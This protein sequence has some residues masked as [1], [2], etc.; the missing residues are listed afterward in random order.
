MLTPEGMTRVLIAAT[1]SQMEPVIREIYRQN[2]F[3][4]EEFVEKDRKEYE[5]Y[6]IGTPLPQAN[7]TSRELLRLRGITNAFMIREDE[8]GNAGERQKTEHLA[9]LIEKELPS[10]EKGVEDLLAR[11][12]H[13]DTQ[14]K[15]YEQK[16]EGLKP[17]QD[18]PLDL[19]L[20]RGYRSFSVFCGYISRELSLDIPH[21]IY[22]T[23]SKKAKLITLVVSNNDRSAAEQAL[24]DAQFQAVPV[25]EEEGLAKTRIG[26]YESQLLSVKGELEEINRRLD[27]IKKEHKGL[28]LACNEL[29]TADIEMAEAP[30]RFAT[31]GESFIVEGWVPTTELEK[32]RQGIHYATGGKVYVYELDPTEVEDVAPTEYHNVSFAK[33][34]EMLMDVYSRPKY[35]EIDPTLL[36]SIIFPIFFGIILG[37]VG[38]GAIVLALSLG[39]RKIVTGDEGSRL[40]KV[41]RNASIS[42]I[43]FGILYSECFGF[44]LPWSPILFS[45]HLNIGGHAGGHGPDVISLMIM[46]VWIGILQITLGRI[47][48]MINHARQDH[49]AHRIKAILANLGWIMV[50]WGILFMLWA[51]F[52]MPFMPDFTGLPPV[53]M[54][55]NIA[56]LLGIVLILLGVIFIIRDS[57]LEIVELPTILSHVLS[58]ARLVGVGLSSVAIAMVVNFIA[59]GLIIEPQ[60]KSLSAVGVIIIIVGV[61]VFVIGHLLN[62]ILGVLGGALQSIRLQYVEFFTKF[63][64]GGGKKYTPFG[65]KKRFTED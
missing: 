59:I 8:E 40:L 49:G 21:E 56:S 10:L 1:K 46:A 31:I 36:V 43:I 65:M 61:L 54:G 3:H 32:F 50:L 41:L 55:L 4:I 19:E 24:A 6:R 48:G 25:P 47:L 27:E 35:T 26:Y 58:Y 20:L 42:S 7:E 9:G 60:L 57:A 45:R 64:K 22:T 62:T 23:D 53:V 12:T 14:I 17:F 63:Y 37:D 51:A 18:V 5:G 2:L 39:L 38:Y 15:D 52:T 29:L 34:T 28:F 33:P 11:R 13:L 44:A 16:I 30:L